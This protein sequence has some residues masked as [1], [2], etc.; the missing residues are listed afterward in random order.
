MNTEYAY[1]MGLKA[2]HEWWHGVRVRKVAG[3]FPP[4]PFTD[5]KDKVDWLRGF[6]D[7]SED[8]ENAWYA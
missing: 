1:A 3:D 5:A 4:N 7:G 8:A 6:Y 2:G